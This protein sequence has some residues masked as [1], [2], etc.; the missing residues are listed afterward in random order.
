MSGTGN[1][2][3]NKTAGANGPAADAAVA[4]LPADWSNTSRLVR[5]EAVGAELLATRE[6]IEQWGVLLETFD[7]LNDLAVRQLRYLAEDHYATLRRAATEPGQHNCRDIAYAHAERRIRHLAEGAADF[8]T[9]AATGLR[10]FGDAA[11]GL[12]RPFAA[13]L[14]RDWQG[15]GTRTGN[16]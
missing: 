5:E 10:R 13:V 16:R 11:F 7:G 4:T 14:R 15:P 6:F 9:L 8:S 3:E 12:W 2:T 1:T